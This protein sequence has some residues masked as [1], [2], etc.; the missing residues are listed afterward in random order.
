MKIVVSNRQLKGR[1]NKK[2]EPSSQAGMLSPN[3]KPIGVKKGIVKMQ[4]KYKPISPA[5]AITIRNSNR[6]IMKQIYPLV[7]NVLVTF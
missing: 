6:Y 3:K 2:I 1:F 4:K 7:L 5:P